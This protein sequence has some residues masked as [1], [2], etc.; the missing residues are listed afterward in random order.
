LRAQTG[1]GRGG[2]R[3]DAAAGA[4][5]PR[6]DRRRGGSRHR[7]AADHGRDRCASGRR[8]GGHRRQ[9]SLGGAGRD[10]CAGPGW[11]RGAGRRGAR[12]RRSPGGDHVRDQ[13]GRPGGRGA[14]PGQG[15]RD[16]SGDRRCDPSLRRSRCRSRRVARP[17]VL[18]REE[19]VGRRPSGDR[20][21]ADR[22]D[23]KAV[24]I[25]GVLSLLFSLFGTR[26]AIGFFSRRG[27]GQEIREDG[28]QTHITK[29]GTPTMGGIAIVGAAVGG[30]LLAKLSTGTM[31]T[32]SGLLLLF[33]FVGMGLVGF[34]DDFIKVFKQRNL[35]LR[36]RAKM[37]GQTGIALVFGAAAPMAERHDGLRPADLYFSTIHNF[38]PKLPLIV[39]LA[40]IWLIVTATSNAVN[41]T[42]GLD[43]LATG[44]CVM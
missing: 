41:L 36:S 3:H 31:P 37:I 43:G 5:R 4:S 40:L 35:G 7:Q 14:D 29:R 2:D 18:H 17:L 25:S 26:L 21:E 22:G 13:G 1:R 32:S 24:L 38:G 15:S 33:L 11:H 16:R 30:Y 34:L 9:S 19:C 42:D 27:Y 6:G 12:D 23:M 39:V 20:S 44:A 8:R 10:P 28:P